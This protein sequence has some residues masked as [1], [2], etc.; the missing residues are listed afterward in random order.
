VDHIRDLEQYDRLE[1]WLILQK[2]GDVVEIPVGKNTAGSCDGGFSF[3]TLDS[4]SR[5]HLPFE[6]IGERQLFGVKL[7][8]L[9][10]HDTRVISFM[11]VDTEAHEFQVLEG[12]K[13]L[14]ERQQIRTAVFEANPGFWS[15]ED[16]ARVHVLD[17]IMSFGYYL[18]C[19]KDDLKLKQASDVLSRPGD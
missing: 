19:S 10:K 18:K 3:H 11:K 6:R 14:F 2:H 15:E 17:E 12:A 16:I 8:Q 1:K 4:E 13:G 7:D 9:F 5:G